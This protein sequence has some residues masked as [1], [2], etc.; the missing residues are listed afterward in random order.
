MNSFIYHVKK[1]T[2]SETVFISQIT[3]QWVSGF[4]EY[5]ENGAGL[6]QASAAHY[7]KILRAALRKAL[8]EN[9]I[10]RSPCETVRRIREPETE[11]EFLNI[12]EVQKLA[13][14]KWE[15][16][17]QGWTRWGHWEGRRGYWDMIIVK[18]ITGLRGTDTHCA[19]PIC[20]GS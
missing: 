19:T 6:A 15:E 11:L 7:A 14:A 17:K 13:D 10:S 1:F 5:L 2:G 12:D 20:C 8:A 16:G 18:R 9:I 3:S 4:Y